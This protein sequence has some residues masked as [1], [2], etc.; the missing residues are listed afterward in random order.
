MVLV[1][2]LGL[3]WSQGTAE[4]AEA[5]LELVPNGSELVRE[6]AIVYDYRCSVCHG[7]TGRGLQEAKR[8]FPENK[9][10]CTNCHHPFNPPQMEPGAMTPR[11]AFDIGTPPPLLGDDASLDRFGTAA[12]LHAYLEATMPRP[13]PGSLSDRTYL[14]ITA[15]LAAAMEAQGAGDVTER[16]DLD[17]VLLAP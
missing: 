6:G 17:D 1:A 12:T 2:A 11:R 7:D 16:G 5:T 14:A 8:S 3:A 4:D 15:F 13:W 10:T 9:R